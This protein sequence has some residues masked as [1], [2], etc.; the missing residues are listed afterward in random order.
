MDL[1]RSFLK[2][3]VILFQNMKDHGHNDGHNLESEIF[4]L[5]LKITESRN[6]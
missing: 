6:V 5:D 3:S 1:L 4:F 2:Y